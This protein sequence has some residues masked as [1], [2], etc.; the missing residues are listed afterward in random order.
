MRPPYGAWYDNLKASSN[1]NTLS[2][3]VGGGRRVT[4]NSAPLMLRVQEVTCVTYLRCSAKATS[5]RT[6]V[7]HMYDTMNWRVE[8]E[9]GHPERV[10]PD[11][12]TAP[13]RGESCVSLSGHV[14]SVGNNPKLVLHRV[15]RP[16]PEGRRYATRRVL[17]HVER[18]HTR[19]MHFWHK[20]KQ[21]AS[22]C[23][24]TYVVMCRDR[25]TWSFVVCPLHLPPSDKT[26]LRKRNGV[27]DTC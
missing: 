21:D 13:Y 10:V 6:P 9:K 17:A 26:S 1:T 18:K 27:H 22:T 12:A 15:V 2:G 20:F 8:A 16:N 24:V 5:S 14:S 7:V 4:K 23:V 3:C 19:E 25:T 11:V